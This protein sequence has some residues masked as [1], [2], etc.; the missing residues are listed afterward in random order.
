LGQRSLHA[1]RTGPRPA[2]ER[3]EAKKVQ[4]FNMAASDMPADMTKSLPCILSPSRKLRRN[5]QGVAES[6]QEAAA[7]LQRL[8]QNCQ[9]PPLDEQLMPGC[10]ES[11][12]LSAEPDLRHCC[13]PRTLQ[14]Q[15]ASLKTQLAEAQRRIEELEEERQNFFHEG[16]YDLVNAVCTSPQ[17]RSF[18]DGSAFRSFEEPGANNANVHHASPD[19]T[20]LVVDVLLQLVSQEH[21]QLKR[22]QR[23]GCVDHDQVQQVVL[24]H[25]TGTRPKMRELLVALHVFAC[26]LSFFRHSPPSEQKAWRKTLGKEITGTREVPP[27]VVN[28]LSVE[29]LPPALAKES[30]RERAKKM[31]VE[32]GRHFRNDLDDSSRPVDWEVKLRRALATLTA[33]LS[34][35][36]HRKGSVYTGAGGV[37]YTLL[38]LAA[39]GL[40]DPSSSC[41]DSARILAEAERSSD[42]RR[43][44]LLE[45]L[46]GCVALQ[47]W[48][49]QLC[50]EQEKV[51]ECV[52]RVERLAE[53]ACALP[54]GECEVLY[55]RCGF[56]GVVLFLRKHLKDPQLLAEPA[57]EI[58]RQVVESGRRHSREGWPLY[59]EWHDK[60]YLGGAHGIAGILHTLVQLPEELAAAGSDVANL[61][62]QSADK[63]LDG[64][65]VSGN[66]PSSLGSDRDRLVQF[67]H[68][69]TGAVP[70]MLRLA[71]VYKQ[72]R[73][74]QQ[75]QELGHVIWRR[76]LLSTKGLGLCHGTPGNGF[77]FLGLYRQTRD[78]V[79]LNRAL[80]FAVFACE[81]Q[82]DLSQLADRPYS[83][84]EGL[85]GA[86]CFWGSVI[87]DGSTVIL[88]GG[89][90]FTGTWV[91][92]QKQGY[93]ILEQPVAWQMAVSSDGS[94]FE[95][96][97]VDDKPNGEGRLAYI[98]GDVYEG[99]WVNER[100]EGFGIFTRRDGS[101]YEG[102]WLNDLQHGYGIE[103]WP[104]GSRFEGMYCAGAKDGHGKFIWSDGAIY[105][106]S[107]SNNCFHGSG[108]YRWQDGRRYKGGWDKN[109]LHG[110]GIMPGPEQVLSRRVI[111]SE[112]TSMER[113]AFAGPQGHSTVVSGYK[114]R[115]PP[116]HQRDER[117]EHQMSL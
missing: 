1:Q 88:E 11:G 32:D 103:T 82:D 20:Q 17:C 62:C 3:P 99:Q 40:H 84:F 38:H 116:S 102:Q 64:R 92:D 63:L 85:A 6:L 35:A 23:S 21:Q 39:C 87:C 44:T 109:K 51:Q 66:L 105:K 28:V 91:D 110:W 97:F 79:W 4:L 5:F 89:F 55:G 10:V 95:G 59:Y 34:R 58:V 71:S 65:F 8:S 98:S 72:P 117:A 15:N 60:C 47:A 19:A 113:D 78:E 67:C 24:G 25:A 7:A 86:A 2:A 53:L 56:L 74:L 14:E 22:D 26:P 31:E 94:R 108:D 16:V 96:I 27:L 68:G 42:A 101:S 76:G 100:A 13:S 107:F 36:K 112:I 106:G 33:S 49:H 80:H 30:A 104:D 73:Y 57:T 18:Q 12:H 61:I 69:A 50:Q 48:T 29:P 41:V 70:L 75:A 115:G 52:R 37:A 46:A 77:A 111:T 114:V 93:G 83:L 45:G 43:V 81:H 54:E 90:R 9:V